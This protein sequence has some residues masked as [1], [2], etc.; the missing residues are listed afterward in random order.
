MISLT[1][2]LSSTYRGEKGDSGVGITEVEVSANGDL[3]VTLTDSTVQNAGRV[4]DHKI[5][6]GP[7]EPL[8]PTLY[9][10]WVDTN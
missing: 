1:Q 10:L 9:D 3:L 2:L 8:D 6:V 5:T 4:Y 7:T